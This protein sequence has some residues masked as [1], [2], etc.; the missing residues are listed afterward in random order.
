MIADVYKRPF[1]TAGFTAFVLLIPLAATSTSG[2]I[3]RLG[4]HRWN[5]L[6]RLIYVSACAAVIHYLWLVKSH[7]NIPLPFAAVLPSRLC[8]PLILH[9]SHAPELR[10]AAATK[11]RRSPPCP[12]VLAALPSAPRAPNH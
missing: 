6:H 10:P 3:R 7:K 8:Y 1:I 5:M 4:G 12:R 11:S 9:P 2:M